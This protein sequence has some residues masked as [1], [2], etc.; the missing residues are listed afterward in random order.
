MDEA[1]DEVFY[2]LFDAN[3]I[4]YALQWHVPVEAVKEL[5]NYPVVL[6]LVPAVK[7]ELEELAYGNSKT[8]ILAK[9]ALELPFTVVPSKGRYADEE[10]LN[11]LK[12]LPSALI[13]N[14][15]KL[16]RRAKGLKKRVLKVKRGKG[17][18]DF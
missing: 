4:I 3:A 1:P 9:V 6:A 15:D 13:T 16:A 18:A 5:F 11:A 7:K 8:A 12:E 10:L 17:F 2:A 14:D